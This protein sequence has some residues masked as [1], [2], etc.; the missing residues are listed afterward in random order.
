MHLTVIVCYLSIP[1]RSYLSYFWPTKFKTHYVAPQF[2]IFRR[3]IQI[4]PN[5]IEM[6]TYISF[7]LI[8]QDIP[9][10]ITPQTHSVCYRSN[11]TAC[12]PL[13][14]PVQ[15]A[16]PPYSLPPFFFLSQREEPAKAGTCARDRYALQ[17]LAV[18]V[19]VKHS[20]LTMS[21]LIM[22]V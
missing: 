14:P 7:G 6:C 22:F 12:T 17:Q 2:V 20:D 5:F 11:R 9:I 19:H 10:S 18:N 8:L 1:T 13:Y 16:H 4:A 3:T 15:A 21:L